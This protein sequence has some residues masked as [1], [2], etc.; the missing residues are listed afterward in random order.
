MKVLH[1]LAQLPAKT[2]SGIYYTNIIEGFKS[3][4]YT[5]KALFAT[6]DGFCFH[7]LPAC[8][9]YQLCF[10]TKQLPFAIPGMSDIM[11]YESTVYS[12]MDEEMIRQWQEAFR[13]KLQQAQAEFAPDVVILH[14]LWFLTAVAIDIF[15]D[16][17]KIGFCHNTD[18][19]QAERHPQ[20]QQRYA[21]NMDQLDVV[22]ALS[23]AQKQEIAD[24]Y[25]IASERIVALG[26]GFDDKLFYP[27]AKPNKKN[28]DLV[29]AAKIAPSKGVF[30]LVQ[31]FK[32]LS[33]SKANLHLHIIGNAYDDNAWRLAEAVQSAP[34]ISVAPAMAQREL[35]EFIRDKDIFV[36]PSYYEGLGLMAIESLASGLLVVATE[37][38]GLIS[39]LGEKVNDSPVIEYVPLPRL[40]D[41]DQPYA[42][43]I[44]AFINRLEEK[45]LLQIARIEEGIV[46]PAEI[47]AEIASHSWPGIIQRLDQLIS[48]KI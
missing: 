46:F 12:R 43:D 3:Y 23:A 42:E 19:R 36:M 38:E 48:S 27:I 35:A 40:H 13:E 30:E 7:A 16:A 22:L 34:N 18:L 4:G 21:A 10:K 5:Q 26:G 8:D 17:L 15:P 2:G 33:E 9:Q 14:H 25:A 39:L 45:L 32:H 20:L 24:L 37:I 29:F 1:V 28:I 41:I 11:P 6:Q 31:A 44:A 47:K